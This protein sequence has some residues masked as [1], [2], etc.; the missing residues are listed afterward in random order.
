[1][2]A[3]QVAVSGNFFRKSIKT[4]SPLQARVTSLQALRGRCVCVCVKLGQT[5]LSAVR[6]FNSLN[7]CT[8]QHSGLMSRALEQGCCDYN[9]E[10][11]TCMALCPSPIFTFEAGSSVQSRPALKFSDNHLPP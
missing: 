9:R 2:E 1:M 3:A 5:L 8:D 6:H 7:R 10:Y 4:A 11:H